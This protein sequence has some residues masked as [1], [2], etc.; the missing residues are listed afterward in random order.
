[1]VVLDAATTPQQ[2]PILLQPGGLVFDTPTIPDSIW[3]HREECLWAS[4]EPALLYGA[5]GLGKTSLAQRVLLAAIG[6]GDTKVLGY[7]VKQIEGNV[8]YVAADRP[9]QAM[10]SMR[11]MV[12]ESHRDAL[13]ERLRWE[14]HRRVMITTD[15]AGTLNEVA[16]QAGAAGG[17]VVL[18]SVKDLVPRL[19]T[20]EGGAAFN[21]AVQDCVVNGVDV[22]SLHHRRKATSEGRN[23]LTLDDVHGSNWI[24]AGHGSVLALEGI[25]GQGVAKLRHLKTPADI[26][27]PFDID[28]DYDA[29]T[30]TTIGRRDVIEYLNSRNGM[31]ATTNEVLTYM[32]G[33]REHTT[34][35]RKRIYRVLNRAVRDGYATKTGGGAKEALWSS[36]ATTLTLSGGSS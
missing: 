30:V 2:E 35:E 3:G 1:M 26:V 16:Q 22:M 29:G 33:S 10:R 24:T 19:S 11:R 31:H 15:T 5:T 25:A 12:N 18:D 6:I 23:G 27:G 7:P 17:V 13:D 32:T 9:S 20:D 8:L 34:A 4:G 14:T 21:A 28:F 36:T